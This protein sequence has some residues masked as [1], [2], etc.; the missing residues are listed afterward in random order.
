MRHVGITFIA[1]VVVAVC[2]SA[3][4]A[5][6]VSYWAL[7]D[8]AG[9]ASAVNAVGGGPVA[10]LVNMDTTAAWVA[11]HSGGALQFDGGDD[12]AQAVLNISETDNTVSMW[13][14]TSVAS[15][16]FFSVNKSTNLGENDRNVY[17]SG[18]SVYG[19][20]WSEETINS[21]ASGINLAD[22][23][24]HHVVHVYGPGSTDELGKHR[25]YVDGV[26]LGNGSKS[27]SS[28]NWQD[29][30]RFGWTNYPSGA[31]Y[32][33]GTID[34]VAIYD[35]VLTPSQV[36]L[37]KNGANPLTVE[38]TP[39]A[40]WTGT[41]G[42][43]ENAANWSTNTSLPGAG[44]ETFINN[45]GTAQVTG[46]TGTALSNTLT[47]GGT[48]AGT[49]SMSGGLIQSNLVT[50]GAG[51][52]LIISG[53][54]FNTPLINLDG[55]T[56]R[57]D[58][59]FSTDQTVAPIGLGGTVDT[60][61]NNIAHTGVI[62]GAGNLTKAG[63]GT[64][65]LSG[66]AA[67]TNS[68][69]TIL[70]AGKLVLGK[71]AGVSAIGGNLTIAPSS[72]WQVGGQAAN[73]VE[74]A[75]GEQIPNT[76]VI[77]F[78][79]SDWSGFRPMGFTET[80][81]GISCTNGRGV[82]E[83]VGYGYSTATPDGTLIIN[84]S[85]DYTY[86]GWIRNVDNVGASKINIVKNGSGK[87]TFGVNPTQGNV[88]RIYYT[89]TTTINGG[90]LSLVDLGVGSRFNSPITV[91]AG[92]TLE[93]NSAIPFAT[94][95]L[96]YPTISGAG[97]VNKIGTGA[98][99]FSGPVAL[100]GT[101]NVQAGR[102]GS[103]NLIADYSSNTANLNISTGAEFDLRGQPATWGGLGG[104]GNV[105]NSFG[106]GGA[107][108]LT[109]GA[110]NKG[111]TF[112]G[113]IGG[114]G[115]GAGGDGDGLTALRKIGTA[116]QYLDGASS[117]TGTTTV[118]G[119]YLV[120]RNNSAIGAGPAGLFVENGATFQ[121]EHA[122][123]ITISGKTATITGG[124]VGGTRG[125]LASWSGANTWDGPVVMTGDSSIYV[126]SS[127]LTVSD[128]VSGNYNLTKIGA[129]RL[130]LGG[131]SANTFSGSTTVSGGK[132]VLAKPAGTNAVGGDLVIASPSGW[133]NSN[134]GVDLGA[135][136]QIP[137]SAV[138]YFTGADWSGFRPGG[139]TET[140]AGISSPSGRG[141]IENAGQGQGGLVT[142]D[143]TLIVN[144]TADFVYNGFIRNNDG[145]NSTKLN[146]VKS[147][148]GRLTFGVNPADGNN[149]RIAY[150][151][152]TTINGGVLELVDLKNGSAFASPVTVNTGGTLEVNSSFAFA[153]RWNYAAAIGGNGTVNK[154]G[155]GQFNFTGPVSLTATVNVLNG[156]LGN[157]NLSANYAANTAILNISPGAE[158]DL[159]GQGATWGGVNGSGAIV[160]SYGYG[161]ANI[162]TVGAA[163]R[164]GT[165]SGVLSGSGPGSGGDNRGLTGLRKI[166]SGTQTLAGSGI[167]YSGPT[168]VEGGRLVLQ[169]ASAFASPVALSNNAT[170]EL[171]VTSGSQSLSAGISGSGN[172]VKS[173]A[174]ML[175]AQG[176][177]TY[178]GQTIISEGV[179]RLAMPA[180]PG[181]AALWLDA[182]DA[183]S[184]WTSGGTVYQWDDKSGNGRNLTQGNAANQPTLVSAAMNGLAAV[185]F[186][187]NDVMA[188][189]FTFTT[190][191]SIFTA[192][193]MDGGQNYRLI[194][195]VNNNWLL[196]YWGGWQDR[197][198][199]EGW[200]SGPNNPADTATH[201]YGATGD[202]SFTYF[203]DGST[204]ITA[205]GSGKA[206]PNGISLGAWK[207]QPTNESS[208]GSVGEV[209][210]YSRL[211]TDLERQDLNAYL[212][213]KWVSSEGFIP[214][215]SAVSIAGGAT[216][217]LNG[218]SETV[219]SLGDEGGSGGTV[220][221]GGA[222]LTLN[223]PA[224]A[225]A[226]FSGGV[227]GTGAI[228]KTGDGSQFFNGAV[229]TSLS[230]VSLAVNDGLVGGTGPFSGPITV[231][232]NGT[233]S[234]GN[235]PGHMVVSGS[236]APVDYTQTGTLLAE[237]GGPNQ[238]FDYDW[239]EV[240][241][242]A[243]VSGT[244]DIDRFNDYLGF[245]PFYVLTATGE[246]DVKDL[247]LDG[248]GA[249][250]G[251]YEW[252]WSLVDWGQ[253]GQALRL[254]LVP[255]PASA[256]LLMLAVP[257]VA[258][259]MRRR[260][261]R[262]R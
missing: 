78:S 115:N 102:L 61:G 89:G 106:Y 206:A 258:A 199:A 59:S 21:S 251:H 227:T 234:A 79:G 160:N 163:D 65:L 98:F 179:Y 20:V 126:N 131:S 154:T 8:A 136:E 92:G 9:S 253:G 153:S 93:I 95:W 146:L 147:G 236:D 173:G 82:I 180:I 177:N 207:N 58:V 205:N 31:N 77:T 27:S 13:I 12:L 198:Y 37:L 232:D 42:P 240:F 99:Q 247:T 90:T 7:D 162:L 208:K 74:L 33:S 219:A 218:F 50:V 225:S 51:G 158:Y 194:T 127:S 49:L 70:S 187:G 52:L 14:R 164:G 3:V 244:I 172:V 196:G 94:R 221:L 254:D 141:V 105:I 60:N 144:N 122:T 75:A 69:T 259:R 217:D 137:D 257:A 55:G 104:S 140:V 125:A 117:Y 255:E 142:V 166:G 22:G 108:L 230:P 165:F 116:V 16:G 62:V 45:G 186:D 118:S 202:G 231:G 139:F 168:S 155:T 237:I 249:A 211:L 15:G 252:R 130:V 176:A 182:S 97:T 171:K 6:P 88:S 200:V 101:V 83:N 123:G 134:T 109:I 111:G 201:L 40:L 44:D 159:R 248:S 71:T 138:I 212:A 124:G 17:L 57:A 38:A 54:G 149:A 66:T 222:T 135:S 191:Y 226:S 32:F 235:S 262:S 86:N 121:L 63:T 24:W 39:Q 36:M 119:G 183:A 26:E 246:I 220:L 53:G 174:G 192:S 150:T 203:Y 260:L 189:A 67:N 197:L 156:H 85:G 41:T 87:L 239:V 34:D 103:D 73:G 114:G 214:D 5:A 229:G 170:V 1:A 47:I 84:N 190:P 132:I 129:G 151:G 43:W 188:N 242:A 113:A 10:T 243:S 145:G 68:G 128:A 28:F 250:Y 228:V 110:G 64:L 29:I 152:T 204:L 18:G 11:G 107:N 56:L 76:A 169:D 224:A 193:K 256:L 91:N 184:V 245:G 72:G 46:T 80:V 181:G 233:L 178:G 4:W 133:S 213:H 223:V 35:A 19:R 157:D 143:G 241:G 238:G 175:V 100:T 195:S 209:V 167:T 261:R 81:G 48:G 112:T 25:L 185:R 30:I 2:A 216:L 96:Y 161:G 215:A 210:I 120:G 148:P 23:Q